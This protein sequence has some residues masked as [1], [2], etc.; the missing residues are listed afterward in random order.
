MAPL[1][2]FNPR[3]LRGKLVT[4]SILLV[5]G[6]LVLA[7]GIFVALT[8][9]QEKQR[10]LD[11]TEAT[12]PVIHGEFLQLLLDGASLSQLQQYTRTAAANYNERILLFD[13][14]GVVVE[15]T[16]GGLSGAQLQVQE[17]SPPADGVS[18][19]AR[20]DYYRTWQLE[21][22]TGGSVIL[23]AVSPPLT[24]RGQRITIPPPGNSAVADPS[25]SGTEVAPYRLAIVIPDDTF[26]RAWLHLLPWLALAAV[27][28]LPVAIASA[29]VISRNITRPLSKLTV[30]ADQ[31]AQGAFDIDVPADRGDEV[32]Q[33][34]RAFS[35]M[36]RSVGE[37]QV[38][39]RALLANV[40][41]DMRTPLTSILGFAQ[42]LRGGVITGEEESKHAGDVIYDEVTKLSERLNDLLFLSEI[43]AGQA[44]VQR[45]DVDLSAL[46]A[47]AVERTTP[48][49]AER[50]VAITCD[51]PSGVRAY[52]D[53]AKLERALENLLDNS[54][55]FTPA[56]GEVRVRAFNDGE[57]Q[58][59]VEVANA[60]TDVEAEELPRLFERFYRRDRAR[61]GPSAGSGLGLPIARDLVELHGGKLEAQLTDSTITFRM[62]L[63]ASAPPV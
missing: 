12:A 63:P 30:A 22:G 8:H 62:T 47:K 33:L 4:A 24:S 15:D 3:T 16:D 60:V 20:H 26:A 28:A 59:C 54:R 48:A 7:S 13:Y 18:P 58:V 35:S 31:M 44:L 6:S 17:S 50:S 23:A 46:A 57:Q 49:A 42:A 39:M 34:S 14:S 21:G 10:E 32:G 5:I 29:I 38:Q 43:E 52:V 55:K 2:A 41:H 27:I 19:P 25:V 1:S 11:H 56:G 45:E 37:T 40:S 53:R 61:T 9:G 51:V 36:A